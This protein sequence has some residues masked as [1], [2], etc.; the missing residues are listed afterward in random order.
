MG[1][2]VGPPP[3][4][5]ANRLFFVVMVWGLMARST[6]MESRSIRPSVGNRSKISRRT[7]A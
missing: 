3:S 1:A 6:M 7:M 4:V 2:H 5:A